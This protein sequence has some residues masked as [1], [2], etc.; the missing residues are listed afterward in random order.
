[1]KN[2]IT[3]IFCSCLLLLSCSK[4]SATPAD[5]RNVKYEITGNF[6]GTLG[7][8]CTTSNGS[9][10]YLEVKTIPWKKEFTADKTT[11]AVAINATGSGG[12]AGQTAILKIY[13]GNVEVESGSGTTTSIGIISLAPEPYIFK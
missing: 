9:A 5:S 11:K 8:G 1:M 2:Q 13:I 10:E 6:K 7:V 12:T 4:D 3:L